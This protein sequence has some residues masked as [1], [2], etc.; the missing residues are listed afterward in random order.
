MKNRLKRALSFTLA[1]LIIVSLFGI[2]PPI[3]SRAASQYVSSTVP[4]VYKTYITALKKAHPKWKFEFFYTGLD[5]STVLTNEMKD[6]VSLCSYTYPKSYRAIDSKSYD[7]ATDTYH[8]KDA[9]GW[10]NCAK[11]TIAYFMDPRNFFNEVDVFQFEKLSYD[12]EIHTIDGVKAIL[13]GSFMDGKT[14]A[15][16]TSFMLRHI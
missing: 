16:R 5:W 13:K 14:P 4:D 1:L 10:Y 11:E 3:E 9:G 12:S 7:S 15:T 6:G 2:L 8:S